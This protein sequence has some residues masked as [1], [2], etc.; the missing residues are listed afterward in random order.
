[1]NI[2]VDFYYSKWILFFFLKQEIVLTD[3]HLAGKPIE[4]KFTSFQV[5]VT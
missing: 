4:L 3:E 2:L 1:V 5:V